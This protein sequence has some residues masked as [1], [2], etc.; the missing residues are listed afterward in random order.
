MG[1][2][3][4]DIIRKRA[5]LIERYGEWWDNF[6]LTDGIWTQAPSRSPNPR[7]T[8]I[9]QIASDLTKKPLSHCRVLDLACANG[10]FSLEFA[11]RGASVLG[12]EGRDAN[13]QKAIFAK[14]VFGL[15][16]LTFAQEDV[17]TISKERFGEFD[18]IVCSGILY[19]L[20]GDS[21][22]EF[23]RCLYDTTTHM[24]IVDTHVALSSAASIRYQDVTYYGMYYR[25]HL[26][27][28]STE[29]KDQRVRSSL[30]NDTSFW[31][32]RPSLLNMLTHAGFSSIH[33]CFNPPVKGT[34][35]RCTL[36]GIKGTPVELQTFPV[37]VPQN[38]DWQ[39]G[40]LTYANESNIK[41]LLRWHLED[42]LDRTGLLKLLQTLLKK[43]GRT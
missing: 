2:K 22:G 35:D 41:K 38:S 18:I 43:I 17:R 39:E 16:N 23:I 28:D 34:K 36:I 37:V 12:I 21:Q 33:E 1:W 29:T 9:L 11:L 40:E 20:P 32:T 26:Q 42:W 31:L 4:D 10:H 25:E 19:H 7:V 24:V 5:E 15:E 14:E 3:R 8:K 6:E 30:E 13:I 27:R